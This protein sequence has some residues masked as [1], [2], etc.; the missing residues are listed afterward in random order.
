MTSTS[1]THIIRPYISICMI[2]YNHETFI[3]QALESILK[4]KGTFSYEIVIGEDCSTD[5]TRNILEAYKKQYPQII[6]LLLH[7]TNI[8]MMENFIQT[9]QACS[10]K[11]IAILEG[12]D[13][14]AD[15]EKLQKQINFLDNNPEYVITYTS[16][17]TFSGNDVVH[18]KSG[19]IEKDFSAE[20]LMQTPPINT[21]TTCFRNV[22]QNFPSE[23]YASKF[24]DLFLWSLLGAYGKGKFIEDIE[25]SMYRMHEGGVFSEKT[26]KQK[27]EMALIT[28]SLLFSYYSRIKNDELSKYFKYRLLNQWIISESTNTLLVYLA[29]L[30]LQNLKR[31]IINKFNKIKF[32]NYND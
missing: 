16:A 15:P 19:G 27:Y 21:L 29:S 11:Y 3:A 30:K 25:P 2:T 13:Y 4:Q 31:K 26:K 20:E 9:L 12:D 14:W 22:L 28:D 1:Q 24:G 23:M 7:D 18:G 32:W 10:G 6:K 8:G 17:L 5:S